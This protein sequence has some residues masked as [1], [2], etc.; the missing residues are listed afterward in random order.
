MHFRPFCSDMFPSCEKFHCC[1]WWSITDIIH[2]IAVF[3]LQKLVKFQ[4]YLGSGE[5]GRG[6]GPSTDYAT[7]GSLCNDVSNG[8]YHQDNTFARNFVF[9][10]QYLNWSGALERHSI[11]LLTQWHSLTF[12]KKQARLPNL[13]KKKQLINIFSLHYFSCN[14][15]NYNEQWKKE[16]MTLHNCSLQANG[17]NQG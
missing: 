4:L 5:G 10:H 2:N 14:P 11:F 3:F 7:A 9:N 12:N 6:H 17:N 16:I 1:E 15:R 8:S 13:L